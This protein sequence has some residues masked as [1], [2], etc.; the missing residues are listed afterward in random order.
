MTKRHRRLEARFSLSAPKI[1]GIRGAT[2]IDVPDIENTRLHPQLMRKNPHHPPSLKLYCSHRTRRSRNE[3]AAVSGG[4]TRSD[5]C[6]LLSA[7]REASLQTPVE[8]G[9]GMDKRSRQE[10][11]RR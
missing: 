6:W 11:V 2:P 4:W 1:A 8:D 5:V 10:A 7:L 3:E 9:E